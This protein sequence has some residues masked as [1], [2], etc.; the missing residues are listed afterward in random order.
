MKPTPHDWLDD[1]AARTDDLRRKDGAYLGLAGPFRA[2]EEKLRIDFKLSGYV[3]H[4]GDK[5][6]ARENLLRAFLKTDANLPR[7]FALSDASSHVL[8][9]TGHE[10][11]QIDLLIYDALNAPRLL[12][13]GGIQY[14]PIESCFGMIESKS[15]LQ[16]RADVIDGLDKVAAF[17]RLRVLRGG[18]A[19][20]SSAFGV[21]VGYTASLKWDTLT[22]AIKEWEAAHEPQLWPNL[23]VVLD[24]GA[25]GHGHVE[26]RRLCLH[27]SE[28]SA[29]PGELLPIARRTDVL[30][31]FYLL[32][33]DMLTAIELGAPPL[34]AYVWLPRSVGEHSYEFTSSPVSG[35][36]A[37][38]KHGPYLR[39][40]SNESIGKI[41]TACPPGTEVDGRAQLAAAYG[42]ALDGT[43]GPARVFVYNPDHHD[44]ARVLVR[45]AI[46]PYPDRPRRIL[47]LSYESVRID[48][49]EYWLPY[50]YVVRD[51][52]ID[53][54][55]ECAKT[56]PTPAQ[57][58]TLT[59]DAFWEFWER[60]A[61]ETDPD[62]SDPDAAEPE[63]PEAPPDV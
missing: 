8:S 12:S 25:F 39:R 17:K 32:L 43:F 9:T 20:P 60:G 28:I 33:L 23:V 51:S 27:T 18:R 34:R 40:L 13:V 44:A 19:A 29:D 4:P 6:N 31:H 62:A 16:S 37:C 61:D 57:A 36:G 3:D 38:S 56:G 54:C 46:I 48:G 1:L 2:I 14:F 58:A 15:D 47:S 52:L 30:L 55:P 63:N 50:Y 53:G 41:L 10:S 5:G 21:L 35:S 24:Q 59:L 7:R 42:G 22:A 11:A 49:R 26:S 45:P